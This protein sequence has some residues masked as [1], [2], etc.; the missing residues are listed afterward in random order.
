MHI[1]PYKEPS[2]NQ[3]M[4]Y[5]YFGRVRWP[6]SGWKQIKD[7]VYEYVIDVVG[8]KNCLVNNDHVNKMILVFSEH[9]YGFKKLLFMLNYPKEV[10]KGPKYGLIAYPK[11]Q[12]EQM[13]FELYA[14]KDIEL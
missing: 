5:D 13:R 12:K 14:Y 3:R 7:G 6:G 1:V 9:H 10:T 8:Y 4:F 11:P 2:F